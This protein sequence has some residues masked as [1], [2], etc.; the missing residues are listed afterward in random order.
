[1]ADLGEGRG[2]WADSPHSQPPSQKE[3]KPA[4]QA[5]NTLPP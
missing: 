5:K 1:M 3:E 2:A 4:G